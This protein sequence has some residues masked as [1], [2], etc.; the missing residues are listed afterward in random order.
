MYSHIPSIKAY[1]QE[2]DRRETPPS[3][4]DVPSI[5]DNNRELL[6]VKFKKD[7]NSL[8]PAEKEK[9]A[10]HLIEETKDSRNYWRYKM[11]NFIVAG[12]INP[13]KY[14]MLAKEK[15]LSYSTNAW[16]SKEVVGNLR[17][18]GFSDSEIKIEVL[19]IAEQQM[20]KPSKNQSANW[21]LIFPFKE[22]WLD[23]LLDDI[24]NLELEY[25]EIRHRKFQLT[26]QYWDIRD[27][28][29]LPN[30]VI[31]FWITRDW[32]RYFVRFK[33]KE[34]QQILSEEEYQD[35]MLPPFSR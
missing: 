8:S 23:S 20:R 28:A 19:S 10:D 18:L 4:S 3:K 13:D 32:K 25:S 11:W 34:E 26:R 31:E 30:G 17:K 16:W 33:S 1:F 24:E 12:T 35:R 21:A 2:F 5:T 29:T 7:P 22:L 6:V 15:A 14:R 27:Y 9:L